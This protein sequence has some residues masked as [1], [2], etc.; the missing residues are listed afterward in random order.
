MCN[1]L[2]SSHILLC[3]H[4]NARKCASRRE[5]RRIRKVHLR[6]VS[7]DMLTVKCYGAQSFYELLKAKVSGSANEFIPTVVFS[8]LSWPLYGPLWKV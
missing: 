4:C 8:S 2:S 3:V 5:A 7:R 1:P 6:G